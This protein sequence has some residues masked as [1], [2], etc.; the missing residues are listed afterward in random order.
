M[1]N[2]YKVCSGNT[3]INI[4]VTLTT[5]ASCDFWYNVYE[6]GYTNRYYR[7]L[8]TVLLSETTPSSFTY[9][10][11][12]TWV[13]TKNGVEYSNGTEVMFVTIPAG[14]SNFSWYVQCKS[15]VGQES[16]EAFRDQLE[17]L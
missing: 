12:N 1:A 15:E 13:T 4:T 14:V 7:K 5:S 6:D 9:R 17:P 2:L 16:G 10:Y 8:L 3:T 11:L